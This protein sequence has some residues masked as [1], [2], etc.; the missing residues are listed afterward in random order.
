MI[1]AAPTRADALKAGEAAA[2]RAGS[3]IRA[4]ALAGEWW[5]QRVWS[6]EGGDQSASS[7]LLR[8][9]GASLTICPSS[10]SGP[11][12]GLG[13]PSLEV[14]NRVRL[15][16]LL[17]QF[18]GPGWLRGKRPLLHFHFERM[19]LLWGEAGG[20]CAGPRPAAVLCP[21]RLPAQRR[22]GVVDSARPGRGTGAVAA[23]AD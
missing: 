16:P 17:L 4:D 20:A 19:A 21:D 14:C 13:L 12:C 7:A 23:Q 18:S 2:R 11:L 15:G 10:R 22:S 9:V 1:E 6:R 3:G 8:A 5:L